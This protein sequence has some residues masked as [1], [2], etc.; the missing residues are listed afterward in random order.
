[1]GFPESFEID[2]TCKSKHRIYHQ[3]GN[4]VVPPVIEAIMRQ[5]LKTGVFGEAD[6]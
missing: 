5:I 1:M 3:L 2:D 6:S 4:A